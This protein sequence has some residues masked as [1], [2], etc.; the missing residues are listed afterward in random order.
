V[1]ETRV[2][3]KKRR[4]AWDSCI[5]IHALSNKK[6]PH[7]QYWRHIEPMQKDAED[8]KIEIL[9]S[10]LVIAEVNV[11]Q[12]P[13]L[14]DSQLRDAV[15]DYFFNDFIKRRDVDDRVSTLAGRYVREHQMGTCDAIVVANAVVHGAEV[16]YTTD[17]LKKDG[18]IGGMLS[19]DK[20]CNGLRIRPPNIAEYMNLPLFAGKLDAS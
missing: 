2:Q 13:K 19:R 3:K 14:T 12:S 8:G 9:I 6:E 18:T 17:G 15:E 4:I 7:A 16:L 1:T 5:V 20:K 10:E 11:G